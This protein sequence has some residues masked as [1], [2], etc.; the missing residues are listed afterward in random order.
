MPASRGS[1]SKDGFPALGLSDPLV[2]AITALGYEE[3]TPVQRE[4]IPLMLAGRDLLAQAATGTGKTAA[5]A[6]PMI[7]RL[8]PREPGARRPRRPR[9]GHAS[10]LV[11]VPDPRTGDA[12]VRGDPQVRPRHRP[13]RRA[14]LRRRLDAAADPALD[15][16]ADVVVATPGRALRPHP[17][18]DARARRIRMLVLDE[19]DEMLDMGFAED[20]EAILQETP[21]TRQTTLFSATLPSRILKIAERHLKTPARVTIA[22]EKT[23]AGKLPRVRQV[24]YI[25]R[26][27]EK[28]AALDRIL[29]MENPTSAIVF[30]RT[31]LEVDTLVETLN[32]HGYRAEALHGGMQQRQRDAVMNRVRSAKTDLLIATDVAA[33]GLDIEHVSHVS[34]TTCRPTPSRTCIASGAPAARDARARRSRSPSPASIGCCDRS[35]RS[36]SRRSTWRRCRPCRTC[37]RAASSSRSAALRERLTAGD[38][39]DVRV[40]VESL[41][42]EFDVVDI[43]AAA[44]KLAHLATVGEGDDKEIAVVQPPREAAGRARGARPSP[45]GHRPSLHRRRANGWDP[46]GGPRGRHRRGGGGPVQRDRRDP[47]RRQLLGRRGARGPRRRRSSRRC[48][49]RRSAARRPW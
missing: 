39:D 21:A 42:E 9:R 37:G 40:V 19:A 29:D 26:H 48:A 31:R 14:A 45:R 23:A 30:C 22:R 17:A 6:L 5:F 41:S 1:T 34:T 7:Q 35:S 28:A 2:A 36:R 43:A 25:V 49:A 44:V 27:G 32:A 8:T 4:T 13:H 15:R 3:P 46:A 11:L 33:R 12:G 24:A 18:Q 38:F 47:H 16:G 10:G 20:L